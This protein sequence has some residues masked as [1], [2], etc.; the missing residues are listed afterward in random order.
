MRG[1]LAVVCSLA[2]VGS[3]FSTVVPA[4]LEQVNGDLI[5][6]TEG[7]NVFSNADGNSLIHVIPNE[8]SH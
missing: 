2:L 5:T 8:Y 1:I 6:G 7:V 3:A 4:R